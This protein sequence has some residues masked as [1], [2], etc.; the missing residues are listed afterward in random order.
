MCFIDYFI[1][2]FEQAVFVLVTAE[3][4]VKSRVGEAY[5]H[6]HHFRLEDFPE[7]LRKKRK[8]ITKMLTRLEGR[9]GYV[10]PDNLR[11]M[12]KK[13][14]VKITVMIWDIYFDLILIRNMDKLLNE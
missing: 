7:G 14:A 10:I 2:K 9:Q 3:G 11:K 6:F 4:D 13:T 8:E 5:C 1:Q 12:R